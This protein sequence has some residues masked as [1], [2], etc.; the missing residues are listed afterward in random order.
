MANN[1]KDDKTERRKTIAIVCICFVGAALLLITSVLKQSNAKA[2]E[3][4][5]SQNN[6]QE[7]TVVDTI[8]EKKPENLTAEDIEILKDNADSE[9]VDTSDELEAT[10][11]DDF[12]LEGIP[13]ETLALINND[14]QRMSDC[15]QETLYRNG[16]YDYTKARFEDVVEIDYSELTVTVNM[17]VYA[18]QV[19]DTS[20]IY[21]R[22][23]DIWET[24]IW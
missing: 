24:V 19:V 8:K 21:H 1:K 22:D 14:T 16:Y 17:K 15:I 2:E 10:Y 11:N 18:N 7:K 23:T 9:P 13:E 3:N 20:V 12:Q 4:K 6:Q 5:N